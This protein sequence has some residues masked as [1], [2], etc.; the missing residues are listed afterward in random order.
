MPGAI[1]VAYDLQSEIVIAILGAAFLYFVVIKSE[2]RKL[3][4]IH[5]KMDDARDKQR[6]NPKEDIE[7]YDLTED[8]G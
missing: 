8:V 6:A 3:E 5:N 4:A 2:S 1:K 7:M